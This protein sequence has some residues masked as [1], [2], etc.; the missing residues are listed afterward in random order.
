MQVL[1]LGVKD[2]I[3]YKEKIINYEN[4]V[5]IT[6]DD[7]NQYK[8]KDFININ[9][10]S[11]TDSVPL[12]SFTI[13][14]QNSIGLRFMEF[15]GYIKTY[16]NEKY[17]YKNKIAQ[18]F[19]DIDI[20]RPVLYNA[21]K[22]SN[23]PE[24]LYT[25]IPNKISIDISK[26]FAIN[27]N[28]IPFLYEVAISYRDLNLN[29]DIFCYYSIS[30]ETKYEIEISADIK[31]IILSITPIQ[32]GVIFNNLYRS[33]N[34][35]PLLIDNDNNL[36]NEN[37]L[38]P[39]IKYNNTLGYFY[40]NTYLNKEQK[41][42]DPK[43]LKYTYINKKNYL[44]NLQFDKTANF[45]T[46]PLDKSFRFNN[47]SLLKDFIY[48]DI[49]NSYEFNSN[50]NIDVYDF[51]KEIV[52]F[53]KMIFG[54]DFSKINNLKF[55]DIIPFVQAINPTGLEI[56][57]NITNKYDHCIDIMK[58][59]LLSSKEMAEYN[60]AINF[61]EIS[62][63]NAR[64]LNYLLLIYFYKINKNN[65]EKL[66]YINRM[67]NLLD[68][69]IN[70]G[71]FDKIKSFKLFFI[72]QFSTFLKLSTDIVPFSDGFYC[73]V[74]SYINT[75]YDKEYMEKVIVEEIKYFLYVLSQ[76][77]SQNFELVSLEL[78]PEDNGIFVK[79]TIPITI[80]INSDLVTLELVS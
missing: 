43:Y 32:V 34:N 29:K 57:C 55:S 21:C 46:T 39:L 70:A 73:N 19:K 54:E 20:I 45:T 37:I 23:I 52:N 30:K 64:D 44:W 24:T 28:Y 12:S 67:V 74:K 65:M 61:I 69:D 13:P 51:N 2:L 8:L 75:K 58:I 42:I 18:L 59:N 72:K 11:H 49:N 47:T 38:L 4:L 16:N 68:I 1:D 66:S 15:N 76:Y 78:V 62:K 63:I 60:P 80:R 6:K 22:S 77:Y 79:L 26:I 41:I 9:S 7:Y 33:E 10:F 27:D 48:K 3:K 31:N 25:K 53:N 50:Y 71:Q 35:F 36:E 40:Y 5:N 17:F 56:N 14:V